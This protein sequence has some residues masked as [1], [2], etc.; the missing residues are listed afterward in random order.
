MVLTIINNRV[1]L[2]REKLNNFS[3]FD[4]D[5]GLKGYLVFE[6]LSENLNNFEIKE[7]N[8]N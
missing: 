4:S 1:R 2:G 6:L 3:C 8:L 7:Q 5:F